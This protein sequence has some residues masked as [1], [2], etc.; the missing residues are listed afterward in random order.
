MIYFLKKKRKLIYSCMHLLVQR[1]CIL[2]LYLQSSIKFQEETRVCCQREA[3][4]TYPVLSMFEEKS[5][6]SYK[7]I[8]MIKSWAFVS[9]SSQY[10]VINFSKFVTVGSESLIELCTLYSKNK[11]MFIMLSLPTP[12]KQQIVLQ[13]SK[14]CILSLRMCGNSENMAAI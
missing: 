12:W 5:D 4:S 11:N 13:G 6:K 9:N 10:N 2:L 14:F 1:H 7:K 3:A 8:K